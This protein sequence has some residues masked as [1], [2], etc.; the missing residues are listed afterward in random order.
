MMVHIRPKNKFIILLFLVLSINFSLIKS[1]AIIPGINFPLMLNAP[2]I[3]QQGNNLVLAF[4]LPNES[5]GL[6]YHEYIGVSF[7]KSQGVTDLL[8]D[9][10]VYSNS[11]Q[12]RFTCSLTDSQSGVSIQVSSQPA[13]KGN[14]LSPENNVLYCRLDDLNPLF[15]GRTYVLTLALDLISISNQF[16]RNVGIFTSTLPERGM[17]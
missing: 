17:C 2:L 11:A 6:Q 9:S 4:Q 15:A 12:N 1:A 16:I 5:T 13:Q 3:S 8:S 10:S 14:N 7:P